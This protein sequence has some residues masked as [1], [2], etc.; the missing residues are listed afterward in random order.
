MTSV[1]LAGVSMLT[2]LSC[3]TSLHNLN[4]LMT[5]YFLLLS[6]LFLAISL[7]FCLTLVLKAPVPIPFIHDVKHLQAGSHNFFIVNLFTSLDKI[8]TGAEPHG[9]EHSTNVIPK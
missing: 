7:L 4:I 9:V 3:F 2:W 6:E 1:L 8:H 5:F